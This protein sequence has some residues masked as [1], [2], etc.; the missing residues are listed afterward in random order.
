M[1]QKY[2]KKYGF[3]YV[4]SRSSNDAIQ[5][6]MIRYEPIFIFKI[7]YKEKFKHIKGR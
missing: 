3:N 7:L 6:D 5:Y 1:Y 2:K 4:C